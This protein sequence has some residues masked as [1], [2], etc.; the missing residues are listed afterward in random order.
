M[1]VATLANTGER[2][3]APLTLQS[4]SWHV[5]LKVKPMTDVTQTLS[6]IEQGDPRAAEQL[7]Q[8]VYD[9]LRKL[10]AQ[11]LRREEAGQTLQAAA[12]V[13]EGSPLPSFVN[14]H[15]YN[16]SVPGEDAGECA[17]A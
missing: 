4:R 7:L 8:V 12:L 16:Y 5:F 9:E 2:I 10:A 1:V 11:E 3:A 14:G 17:M 13:H 6:Q 15:A